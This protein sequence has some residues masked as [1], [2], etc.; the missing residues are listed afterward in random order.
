MSLGSAV[1]DDDDEAIL[2]YIKANTVP[3]L[4]ATGTNQMSPL[5]NGGVVNPRLQIYGVDALRVFDCSIVP[6][7]P[8]V[9]I[10]A[11]IHMI[12]EKGKEMIKEDWEDV[13]YERRRK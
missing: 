2:E 1:A 7:L 3:N 11:A 12:A 6:V 8:D 4:H 10:L 5:E 13:G 9:D